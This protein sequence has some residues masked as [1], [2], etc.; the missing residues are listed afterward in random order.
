L[1][2]KASPSEDHQDDGMNFFQ[3]SALTALVVAAVALIMEIVTEASP[4]NEAIR[5]LAARMF[6]P[7]DGYFYSNGKNAREA[8]DRILLIDIGEAT[9]RRYRQPWPLSYGHHARLLERIRQGQP[10]AVFLDIQFESQR[11]D[12]T[13]G[14]L[15]ETLCAF[16]ADDIPVY[17]AAG[18]QASQGRLRPELETLRDPQ[19]RACFKKVS[20]T[21]DQAAVDRISW[22]YPLLGEVGDERLPSAALA[23]AEAL[24]GEP[25][26]DR[27]AA[28]T[29]GLVWGGSA[30]GQGPR[31]V[32]D[33]GSAGPTAQPKSDQHYCRGPSWKDLVPL[34]SF[35]ARLGGFTPDWRPW[36]PMQA[37][38]EAL[39]LTAPKSQAQSEEQMAR[40]KN[41]AI[42]YGVSTDP[43]DFIVSPLQAELPG[44]HLH[45]QA[46]DNLLRFGSQWRQP[47]IGARWGHSG[48]ML[49][50]FAAFFSL[51]LAFTLARS[52]MTRAWGAIRDTIRGPSAGRRARTSLAAFLSRLSVRSPVALKSGFSLLTDSLVHMGGQ[53]VLF[54]GA[55]LLAVPFSFVLER[56]LN[57]SLIGYSSV[58]AF[59]LFGELFAATHKARESLE[60]SGEPPVEPPR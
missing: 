46:T 34:Q 57:V 12:P 35:F 22:T 24:Q 11:D 8:T 37:S 16:R 56:L 53:I 5:H 44:M 48:E 36:C 28:S 42:I 3:R 23:L 26:A 30:L 6:A 15:L 9:L 27:N 58:L 18:S 14:A 29:M 52:G 33:P 13:L 50:T 45:A 21:Y 60:Q 43:N 7:Y 47:H 32:S 41:R 2:L 31:W 38:I 39:E 17:L 25:L 54:Y 10:A 1:R 20:V 4:W 49:V 55:L 40:I 19:G 59:C 51:A